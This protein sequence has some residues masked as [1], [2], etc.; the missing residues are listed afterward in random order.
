MVVKIDVER[1]LL[2]IKGAVPGGLN[3]LVRVRDAV[4]K[5]QRQ[6]LDLEYPTWIPPTDEKLAKIL[7]KTLVW[8]GEKLDPYE[9]Y[10]H[11]NDVVSG[12]EVEDE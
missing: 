4:K 3:T 1:S 9:T 12:K 11:E 8:Q 6:Y 2:Y 10:M 7:P 5:A